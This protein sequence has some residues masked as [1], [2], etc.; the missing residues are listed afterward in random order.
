MYKVNAV[1]REG[2]GLLEVALSTLGLPEGATVEFSPSPLRFTGNQP[3][4]QT[5][6]MT[7][8]CPKV[9][10]LDNY[11]FNVSG[12]AR[13]EAITV[14]NQVQQEPYS[15][16]VGPPVLLLD[17]LSADSFR[18]RGKGTTGQTYTIEATPTLTKPVWTPVGSSTADGNGRFT[19]FTAQ[20]AGV[21]MQ[22]YRAVESAQPQPPAP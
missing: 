7:V 16:I 9:T 22:F 15:V 2:S 6:I 14:T 19:C 8:T 11:P 5:A 4:N 1:V 13:R 12:D 20:V 10:P 17:R 3:T 18:L 21:P